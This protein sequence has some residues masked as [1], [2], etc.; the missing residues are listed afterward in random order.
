L[1]VRHNG[2]GYIDPMNQV[3]KLPYGRHGVTFDPGR[4][5]AKFQVIEHRRKLPPPI[6]ID[7]L[8]HSFEQPVGSRPLKEIVKPTDT[9]CIVTSDGTRPYVPLRFVLQGILDY[10][11][12]APRKTVVITGSGSHTPHTDAELREIVG[13]DL[14]SRV[15]V[16]SHDSRSAADNLVVGHFA[17]GAPIVMNRQYV[18]ADKRIVLGHI[19]PHLFAGFT[20]GAK[21][22]A[23]AICGIETIHHLHS[24]RAIADASSTYG[25]I[26][27]NASMALMREAAQAA[28]PDFL[29]NLILNEEQKPVAVFAGDYIEAH[30]TG[31]AQAK[32]WAEAEVKGRFPIVVTSNSGYPLD[33]N[34]YQ[35]VKGMDVACRIVK[36]GGTIIIAAECAKG[37][38]SGSRFEKMLTAG[39]SAEAI[40]AAMANDTDRIDD[41]WQVQRLCQILAYCRVVLISSL[42]RQ[43]VTRCKVGYAAT[44]EQALEEALA[45]SPDDTDVGVLT[46]GPLTLP[47]II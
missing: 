25:D 47:R 17:D 15:S 4:F 34:L 21:G 3:I 44:V 1:V 5:K 13:D 6:G 41:R 16:I 43:T 45:I 36:P 7:D 23:P 31:V 10:L 46:Y 19:E 42:D 40:L 37:V 27:Q 26:E 28:P 11:G 24:Y 12:F 2:N 29:V 18:E 39:E 14:L 32:Q 30:R 22:I 38:P 20:G 8:S 33:Q 9:L 35:T